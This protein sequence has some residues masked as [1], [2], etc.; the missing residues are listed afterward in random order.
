MTHN[1][2]QVDA[3]HVDCIVE[4]VKLDPANAAEH[5]WGAVDATLLAREKRLVRKLDCTLMPTIWVLYLFNY[6]DR[7]NIAQ[8]KLDHFERDLGLKG[9]DFNTAVSILNV[10]Y[11]LMQLPS[12]MLLTKVR[13]SLYIPFW[14]CVWSCVSA[15]T[16]GV[17]SYQG[18]VAVRFF[19]GLAEAPFFPG[20]FYLL[21][22]W[23]T[24]KELAL[25]TAILY[26]GLVLATAFSGLI[27]AGVFAGLDGTHGLRGWQWLF[28][29]TGAASLSFGIAAFFFVP[30][31]PGAAT[32]SARWLFTEDELSLATQR[33]LRQQVSNQESDHSIWYGLKLAAMDF[34]VW[35]F[36]SSSPPERNAAD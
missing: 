11:M 36:V 20:V 3:E 1:E 22:C 6:L 19:L 13:P 15:A 35:V 21:S 5:A 28:I 31:Y 10:G 16:A 33:I 23:Y 8:A 18:L 30:D 24:K 4:D 34:R 14:V 29:I 26:S 17:H 27:A 32:G 12:N 9:T 7:N 2:K 25:R